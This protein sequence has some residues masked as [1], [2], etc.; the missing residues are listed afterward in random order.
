MKH[1]TEKVKESF[2]LYLQQYLQIDSICKFILLH[3]EH[4]EIQDSSKANRKKYSPFA[5]RDLITGLTL[6]NQTIFQILSI[7]HLCILSYVIHQ[8]YWR[9]QISS[10][11]TVTKKEVDLYFKSYACKLLSKVFGYNFKYLKSDIKHV[12]SDIAILAA[13]M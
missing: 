11:K 9:L 10:G 13:H 12:S 4:E 1:F 6:Q 5:F 8:N 3:K 7:Y 2:G